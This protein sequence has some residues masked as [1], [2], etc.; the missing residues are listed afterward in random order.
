MNKMYTLCTAVL[1]SSSLAVAQNVVDFNASDAWVGYMNVFDLPGDG[2]GYQFGSSWE[3]AAL[4][5]TADV[6]ANTLTLQPNFSTYEENP[7]DEF[8]INLDT[9]MGNKDMEASTYVEPGDTYNGEDLKFEGSVASYTLSEDYTASFFIKALDPGADYADVFGGS[10][11]VDLPASGTFS[12]EATGADL[13][14]GLIIQYGFTIRGANA[15]PLSEDE[16]G[17]VVIGSVSL[18]T[19]EIEKTPALS[20]YPNPTVDIV[21]FTN[22]TYV[23]EYAVMNIAGQT[24]LT[25]SNKNT[26]DVSS[27]NNGVYLIQ[28]SYMDVQRTLKFVKK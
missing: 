15:N 21:S 20:L 1:F 7:G 13:P 5:S 4:K 14:D 11:V 19:G 24:V 2:G 26:I 17:S 22:N 18:S 3:V 28:F 12:I 16:L 6:G 25:G 10:K 27:L 23:N 8:W 9:E